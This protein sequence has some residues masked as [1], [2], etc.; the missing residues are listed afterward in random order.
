M[1]VQS[2]TITSNK[3]IPEYSVRSA[4]GTVTSRMVG[5]VE[6]R[7][8]KGSGFGEISPVSGFLGDTLESVLV[9]ARQFCMQLP[10]RNMEPDEL[11]DY[12]RNSNLAPI[13]ISGLE[14]AV[15]QLV[16][17]SFLDSYFAPI[18]LEEIETNAIIG[19]GDWEQALSQIKNVFT[20]GIKTI[21]LKIGVLP[22]HEE[23]L[24]LNYIAD[25][26][27]GMFSV[28]LD[29]NAS[30][31][32]SEAISRLGE[33]SKFR[34]EYIEQPVKDVNQFPEI[35][36]RTGVTLAADE[37]ACSLTEIERICKNKLASVII[38]KP[39]IIGSLTDSFS[40]FSIAR[41]HGSTVIVTNTLESELGNRKALFCA[42]RMPVYRACGVAFFARMENFP[43][44]LPPSKRNSKIV[45]A[46]PFI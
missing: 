12:I 39:S 35:Y 6:I 40:A 46:P 32:F 2:V 3:L 36:N 29:A 1:I 23:L 13:A 10:G 37:S 22:L 30:F 27:P 24:L 45:I 43:F 41:E 31:T 42:S 5:L 17:L 26:Y 25:S 4:L 14:Q 8:V 19:A 21:K 7:T 20:S 15:L 33:Y 38:L 34:I 16:P 44:Y 9:Q 28:R 11:L 18:Q